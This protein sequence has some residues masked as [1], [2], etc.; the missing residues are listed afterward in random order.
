MTDTGQAFENKFKSWHKN[1]H[2]C[3]CVRMPD[4]ANTGS[5]QKA[6]CDYIV[7][8]NR[9]TKYYEL[10]HTNSKTSFSFSNIPDHQWRN[11]EDVYNTGNEFIFAIEDGNHNVYFVPFYDLRHYM[12]ESIL[13][14]KKSVKFWQLE[15]YKKTKTEYIFEVT[16]K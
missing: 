11:A 9:D 2:H 6:L 7:L 4:F 3:M 13:E 16:M 8:Y 5:S 10:K 14:G 15:K 12:T 1:I